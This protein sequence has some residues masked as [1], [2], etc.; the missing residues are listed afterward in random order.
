MTAVAI[1]TASVGSVYF[2]VFRKAV[3]RVYDLLS[4]PSGVPIPRLRTALSY[5]H[6]SAFSVGLQELCERGEY[7]ISKGRVRRLSA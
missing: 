3:D 1:R 5:F 7:E 4:G 6:Q 2:D